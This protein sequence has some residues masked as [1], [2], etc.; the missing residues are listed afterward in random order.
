MASE[1]NFL[2]S[3]LPFE[4]TLGTLFLWK[5]H[6]LL[7][8][9]LSVGSKRKLQ[10]KDRR[11]D[12]VLGNRWWMTMEQWPKNILLYCQSVK[13]GSHSELN[14]NF[15]GEKPVSFF[16]ATNFICAPLRSVLVCDTVPIE[17]RD[18]LG[19]VRIEVSMV[20]IVKIIFRIMS[21]R[22]KQYILPEFWKLCPRI[23]SRRI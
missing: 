9:H 14:T 19:F 6:L 16:T 18:R 15:R 13:K 7:S 21:R 4:R 10:L 20:V 17:G 22:W 8:N 2:A 12:I 23:H 1:I 3:K 11:Y 5:K